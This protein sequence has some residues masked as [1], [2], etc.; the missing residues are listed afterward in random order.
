VN[1]TIEVS[2]GLPFSPDDVDNADIGEWRG[3]S[4]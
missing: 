3:L 1:G 4:E 2:A